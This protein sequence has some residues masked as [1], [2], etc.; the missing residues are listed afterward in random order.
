MTVRV[1]VSLR[2]DK[3]VWKEAKKIAIDKDMRIGQFVETA[4]LHE[5]RR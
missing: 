2:I 5:M 4:L 1:S 3:E